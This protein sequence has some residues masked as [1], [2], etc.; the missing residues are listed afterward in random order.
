MTSY[1]ELIQEYE[2]IL[3]AM[4]ERLR[5]ASQFRPPGCYSGQAYWTPA[6]DIYET[7]QSYHMFLELAGVDPAAMT[8]T[9]DGNALT[10]SGERIRLRAE[11]CSHIHQLEVSHGGFQ[12]T[13]Q[14][15]APLD[16]EGVQS[17]YNLGIFE[18]I[19]PK[20]QK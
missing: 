6:A 11:D 20:L 3:N 14:F 16:A 17:S 5:R 7:A 19:A 15:P 18:I 8:L 9:V 1:E 4:R 13:F 10:V 12:R 2:D